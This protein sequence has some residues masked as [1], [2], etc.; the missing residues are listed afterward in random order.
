MSNFDQLLAEAAA[1]FDLADAAIDIGAQRAAEELHDAITRTRRYNDDTTG[2]RQ[3]SIAF[4][5]GIEDD[6][7][8]AAIAR[9]EA[10]NPGKTIQEEAEPEGDDPRSI[11]MTAFMYY[12]DPLEAKTGFITEAFYSAKDAAAAA[13]LDTLAE[14]LA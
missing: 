2:T 10:A 14:A 9:G 4:V 12:D 8:E 6:Q 13:I 3:S 7:A 11:V 1:Y 5:A